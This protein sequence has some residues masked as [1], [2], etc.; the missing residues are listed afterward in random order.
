M[1]LNML[2]SGEKQQ[3]FNITPDTCNLLYKG[4]SLLNNI[5][6]LDD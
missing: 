5:V 4:S 1:L 3:N 6:Y 2:Y